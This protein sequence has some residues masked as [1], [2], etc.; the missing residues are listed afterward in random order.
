MVSPTRVTNLFGWRISRSFLCTAQDDEMLEYCLWKMTGVTTEM[1]TASMPPISFVGI[2][3]RCGEKRSKRRKVKSWWIHRHP[4]PHQTHV[5]PSRCLFLVWPNLPHQVVQ[6]I[7]S[8]THAIHPCNHKNSTI[9]IHLFPAND[10][11]I[12]RRVLE[13]L[14]N[15]WLI[16]LKPYLQPRVSTRVFDMFPFRVGVSFQSS[17]STHYLQTNKLSNQFSCCFNQSRTCLNLTRKSSTRLNL[18]KSCTEMKMRCCHYLSSILIQCSTSQSSQHVTRLWKWN[19]P[20]SGRSEDPD[21]TSVHSLAHW[22][23][24]SSCA[25]LEVSKKLDCS[26]WMEDEWRQSVR[27]NGMARQE[28][29][30]YI[31]KE[32]LTRRPWIHMTLRIVLRWFHWLRLLY[33][34]LLTRTCLDGGYQGHFCAR[35]RMMKC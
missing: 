8:M 14:V 22:R 9:C 13:S 24:C 25:L 7:S 29:N 5:E 32:A 28:D 31:A 11:T 6:Q 18:W 1:F 21:A 30:L 10:L 2:S 15:T 26:F 23:L 27:D 19:Q 34:F 35:R 17:I 3:S 20:L 16:F 33:E 4:E 12:Q